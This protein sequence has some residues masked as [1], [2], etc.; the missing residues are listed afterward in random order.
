MTQ[1]T[2][3]LSIIIPVYNRVQQVGDTVRS[4]QGL[5]QAGAEAVFVDDGSHDGSAEVIRKVAAEIGESAAIRVIEQ[6]NAGPGAARNNGARQAL[7]PWLAFLDSDDVWLPWALPVLTDLLQ[8]PDRADVLFLRTEVFGEPTETATWP[9]APTQVL[10]H[11][12][13]LAMRSAPDRL[14]LLGSC[15]LVMRR[16]VFLDYEGFT[17]ETRC[18]E[19][20]D[21]FYRASA[22]G[23][24]ETV[25]EPIMVGFR[26]G[27]ADS[28]GRDMKAVLTGL[29]FLT[30]RERSGAYGPPDATRR[31]AL[32]DSVLYGIRRFFL[33]GFPKY[34]Y[35]LYWQVLPLLLEEGRGRYALSLGMMPALSLVNP[36]KYPF[37]WRPAK[38]DGSEQTMRKVYTPP[39]PEG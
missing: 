12:T 34:G 7:A 35:R 30:K 32:I 23:P 1:V 24:V 29:L 19:D 2:P 8:Q 38:A 4:L 16:K 9:Q 33:S 28:L 10:R 3:V 25:A 22:L 31:K 15:N 21:L 14:N 5:G 27:G 6:A 26:F 37:R 36:S 18:S 13:M 11:D 39:T 17:H 20:T